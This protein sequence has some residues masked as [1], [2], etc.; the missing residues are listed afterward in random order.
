M[1]GEEERGGVISRSTS[2]YFFYQTWD[3]KSFRINTEA[4]GAQA[5]CITGDDNPFLYTGSSEGYVAVSEKE[6]GKEEKEERQE[7][8]KK[9]KTKTKRNKRKRENKLIR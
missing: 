8:E 4:K 2:S 5:E 1:R 9:T 6:K 7:K 3:L